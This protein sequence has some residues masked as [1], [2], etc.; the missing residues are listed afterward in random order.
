M[1]PAQLDLARQLA[2]LPGFRWDDGMLTHTTHD[3]GLPCCDA[4]TPIRVQD[5]G[6][7]SLVVEGYF[8]A[9]VPDVSHRHPDFAAI[10]ERHE[11]SITAAEAN[12]LPDLT[13]DATGGVLLGWLAG[14]DL[15][16]T[17]ERHSDGWWDVG[18][19]FDSTWPTGATLAEACARAL[20]AVGRCA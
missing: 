12:A 9:I 11:A 6:I 2:A 15:R 13:D 17:A 14:M 18:L 20:V 8:G 5:D 16:P 3:A 10:M 7:N 4:G 1:T 19:D